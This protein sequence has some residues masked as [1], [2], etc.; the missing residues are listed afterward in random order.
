MS[1]HW[2]DA[3]QSKVDSEVSKSVLQNTESNKKI[4][5]H[6][7]WTYEHTRGVN[8]QNYVF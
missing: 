6:N 7:L 3:S 2:G 8:L 4:C 5:G 1:E